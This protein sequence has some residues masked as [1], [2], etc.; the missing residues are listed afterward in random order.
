MEDPARVRVA[1][2][3][4][5]DQL[6]GE[7]R[8]ARHARAVF[9]GHREDPA[10]HGRGP[11][12]AVGAGAVGARRRRRL[13]PRARRIA[14]V[15]L[16]ARPVHAHRRSGPQHPRANAA[17]GRRSLEPGAAAPAADF[18]PHVIRRAVGLR[19]RRHLGGVDAR[20][21]RLRAAGARRRRRA[22]RGV[23][24][25]GGRRA[26]RGRGRRALV[27]G[28]EPAAP[29]RPRPAA[30]GAP[31]ADLRPRRPDGRHAAGD[32]GRRAETAGA[33]RRKAR[34][35]GAAERAGMGGRGRP[36][37][38]R[39]LP[40]RALHRRHPG[41]GA[42]RSDVC[43][44]SD[45]RPG[46]HRCAAARRQ[47]V[48]VRAHARLARLHL[49]ASGDS[50]ARRMGLDAPR[51]VP[52]RIRRGADP[53]PSRASHAARAFDPDRARHDVRHLRLLHEPC[54]DGSHPVQAAASPGSASH[55]LGA[56]SPSSRS[57]RSR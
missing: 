9:R 45:G 50:D 16:L 29:G 22:G 57:C 15:P 19:V 53:C 36:A 44:W 37:R 25:A 6:D 39:G 1:A 56:S 8:R 23:L 3:A 41:S 30:R 47:H 2:L 5:A 18:P 46:R 40:D 43:G 14:R 51:S 55:H 33:G 11:D 17:A 35:R 4:H 28:D 38:V 26:A 12:G 42:W 32:A 27:A 31:R 10:D 21:G 13:R 48:R 34:R 49:R 7:D 24:R 20:A 52:G 54:D